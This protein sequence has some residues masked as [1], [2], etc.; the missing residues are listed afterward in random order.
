MSCEIKSGIK[1]D[2]KDFGMRN[3]KYADATSWE[4]KCL[5]NGKNYEFNFQKL[6]LSCI[7]KLQLQIRCMSLEIRRKVSATDTV[8][9]VICISMI[10]KPMELEKT[11]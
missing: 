3:R 8:L 1:I 2:S 5:W 9:D 4:S 6:N 11:I 7:L 10:V